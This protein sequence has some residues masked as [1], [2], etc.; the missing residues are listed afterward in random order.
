MPRRLAAYAEDASN[1]L[2]VAEGAQ[3]SVDGISE[4]KLYG[5][6]TSPAPAVG[7]QSKAAGFSLSACPFQSP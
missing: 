7:G 5:C 3:G 2:L 6:F 1:L 4:L